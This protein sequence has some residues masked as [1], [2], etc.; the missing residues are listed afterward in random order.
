[1][2]CG[3]SER[4][5]AAIKLGAFRRSEGQHFV[6]SGRHQDIVVAPAQTFSFSDEVREE[7]L[8]DYQSRVD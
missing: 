5:E 7:L 8:R 6:A 4:G 3:A 2:I 1:M